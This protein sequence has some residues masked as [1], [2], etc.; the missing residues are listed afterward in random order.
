MRT[1]LLTL[2]LTSFLFP[3]SARHAGEGTAWWHGK[4]R[5]LRYRPDGEDFVIVNGERRFTRALYGTNT[6]FR[7][8]T[9]DRPEF[10]FYMPGMGGNVRLGLLAGGKSLWLDKA[11][12]VESRY[13]PGARLYTVKD[14][15]MGPKGKIDLYVL[16]L[17][18][19]EGL[20]LRAVS[21]GLPAGTELVWSYG[22][23]SGARL[24]RNGD[25]NA[26]PESSFY[27]LP[28]YCVENRL[29]IRG[30]TFAL[31]FGNKRDTF[32]MSGRFP[33]GSRL[34]RGDARRLSTPAE[35]CGVADGRDFPVLIGR[36]NFGGNDT[37]FLCLYNTG[38]RRIDRY[39][40]LPEVFREAETHR[41][42]VAGRIRIDTPDPYLNAMG[43][44]LA[45][46]ADAIW[47]SPSYLHGAIGWRV[48]LPGWRGAYAGDFLGWHDRARE[49]FTAYAASQRINM[50]DKPVIMDTVL[51]L[52]RTA[53]IPG[54]PMYSSGY[55]SRYPGRTEDM[56]HY[57]MNL[58]YIDALLWHLNWTGDTAY[59]RQ[60]WPVLERH[61]A[62]EK[63]NFD[64]D[65]DGLYD[66]YCCIWASDA[67]QYG[68][69]NVT[70]SSAY[71][72]RANRIAAQIARLLGENPAPYQAEADK[73]HKAVRENLWMRERGHWAEFRDY[74]GRQ[75]L[76]ASPA[77]WTFYHAVDSDLSSD[78]LEA[79]Q[80]ARYVD[81]AIPHIPV[82]A[83]GYPDDG[84]YVVA[85]TNW[86]PY[87]W[88][89]N[90]VAFAESAHT[91]LGLWQAGMNERAY[92]LFKGTIL[93]AMYLGGSPGNVGQ[94]SFYDAARGETYRDFADPTGAAARALVQG[95]FGIR[96]DALHGKLEIR[97]GLPSSWEHASFSTPDVD[98]SYRRKGVTETYTVNQRLPKRCRLF[99]T[100]PALREFVGT[101]TVNG[102]KVRP[103][104]E[105][106]VG[107]PVW[108]IDCGTAE[109]MQVE[110]AWKGKPIVNKTD[111]PDVIAQGDRLTVRLAP[112]Q[113]LEE[114]RDPQGVVSEPVRK[115]DSF[116][117]RVTGQEGHRTL[118][119]RVRQ[120]DTQWYLPVETEIRPA[121]EAIMEEKEGSNLHFRIINNSSESVQG[122]YA[123]NEAE[124]APFE[125]DGRD[126][127]ETFVCRA[128]FVRM[129]T[130]RLRL[131]PDEGKAVEIR[132]T[133][134]NF[135]NPRNTDYEP[136]DMQSVWNDRVTQI[137]RNRYLSPR[138][139]LGTL[140]I[141][142][143]GIGEWCQPNMQADIDD[144]GVRRATRNGLF[145]SSMGIPFTSEADSLRNNVLFT[146]LWDNYPDSAEVSLQGKACHVYLLMAGS[147]NHMQSR[148]V[149]GTV[150]IT[151]ADG[152]SDLLELVNPENWPPIEQDYFE[153]GAAFRLDAPRPYRVQL[154]T[155]L[156]TRNLGKALGL[157]GAA[158]R[159]IPGGAAVV[160]DLPLDPSKELRKL[161][162]TTHSGEAVIGLMG[163]TLMRPTN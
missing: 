147:T 126:T 59:A 76:H 77:V 161:T 18:R 21:S 120:G 9:G 26:D 61:L 117:G 128:S 94:V 104:R 27:L 3:V 151:Y 72:Y 54:T 17:G 105:T 15:A 157:K 98:F 34:W 48:Q 163:I 142:V 74:G 134:W 70:H 49:H 11:E 19:G 141:P 66:A 137:F 75:R 103:L 4:K 50:P 116:S 158:S 101:V 91:A 16:A 96:P 13:R 51:N 108:K 86:M 69:G 139:P 71:N 130:N 140:Q 113:S 41:R 5:E 110:I 99:L 67:L 8:E 133:G 81:R 159:R 47:E 146:S 38:T 37:L 153:D 23:A 97:P 154:S 7:V 114:V 135:R 143:Q 93:D 121:L 82:R 36:K 160:L 162:L 84:S 90:N 92:G 14:P 144:S 58:V 89:I 119:L 56:S 73:I 63:R 46:A 102:E 1:I 106:G 150:R 53:K 22:G 42:A 156:T 111:C 88:S 145:L 65:G 138:Y 95:L 118:F 78:G 31:R 55:I 6:A 129:G 136:V 12:Y 24:S 44:A 85:T 64:P 57:D 124:S 125:L 43:G 112:G 149:N 132:L 35:A 68:G 32:E 29:E 100:V 62:W 155:G 30:E 122:T 109:S 25:M 152:S 60:V 87:V 28:E 79:W 2:L 40:E 39:A 131:F 20:I 123:V 115:S 107:R 148:M 127:S 80:A 10:A 45:V 33:E 83:E 52:A